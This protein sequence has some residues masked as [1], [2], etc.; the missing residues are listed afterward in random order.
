MR[1]VVAATVA[2]SILAA[3]VSAQVPTFHLDSA[4]PK[5]SRFTMGLD[6]MAAQPRG[7]FAT[8]VNQGWGGAVNI[9]Y[10]LDRMGIFS[11]RGDFG[12]LIYGYE[13]KKVALSSTIGGRVTVDLTTTNDIFMASIGPQLMLPGRYVRPFA[14]AAVGVNGF[15]TSSSV[16]GTNSSDQSFAS[17]QNASDGAV[18]Y[19]FG[20]G[21]YF[22]FGDHNGG[23]VVGGHYYNSGE[24]SYLLKGGITDNPDGS[25]TLDKRRSRTDMMVYQIGVSFR[26][27]H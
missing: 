11:L 16:S 3:P 27:S 1:P 9:E 24:A 26:L 8:N 14:N 21:L 4:T 22:P 5:M 19:N 20:G 25:I 15:S 12:G 10:A 6:G 18:A 13:N 23:L 2:L 7:D 17:T